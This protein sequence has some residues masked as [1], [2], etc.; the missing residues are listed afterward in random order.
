M[1]ICGN[2]YKNFHH[3]MKSPKPLTRVF[4]RGSPK[5][6]S[7]WAG[8]EKGGRKTP[9]TKPC[10]DENSQKECLLKL[11]SWFTLITEL[12]AS[13]GQ[14]H[15]LDWYISNEFLCRCFTVASNNLCTLSPSHPDAGFRSRGRAQNTLVSVQTVDWY[16]ISVLLLSQGFS[17]LQTEWGGN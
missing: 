3:T 8:D 10:T 6:G 11:V 2:V 4:I 1:K 17:V 13:P 5:T 16:R 9:K 7:G 12:N 14:E 15:K